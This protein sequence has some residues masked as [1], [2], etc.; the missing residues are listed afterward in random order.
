[1]TVLQGARPLP[2]GAFRLGPRVG[3]HANVRRAAQDAT[4][5]RRTSTCARAGRRAQPFGALIAV[6]LVALVVGL[7]YVAQTV[8]L[9]AVSYETD[10]LTAQRDD[11]A[12]QVRTLETSVLR[13]GTEATVLDGASRIGL[14][15][16]ETRVRLPAR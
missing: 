16:L 6:V 11:L 9:A 8:R 2:A 5:R 12:R 13:W 3:Q 14:V 10:G 4:T 7:I 15:Q 1:M